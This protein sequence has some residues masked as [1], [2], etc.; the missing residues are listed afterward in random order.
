MDTLQTQRARKLTELYN[1]LREPY[2]ILDDRLRLLSDISEA[3]SDENT[4]RIIELENLFERERQMLKCKVVG[5]ALEILRQRELAV[6]IDVI[7]DEERIKPAKTTHRMCEKCKHVLPTTNFVMHSRQKSFDLCRK[8]ASLKTSKTDLSVYRSILRGIQRDERKRGAFS[9]FA[10]I[11]NE[12]DIKSIFDF[13]W[14]GISLLSQSN[15]TSDLR[16]PRWNVDEEWSPWNCICLTDSEAKIHVN[17][18]FCDLPHVYGEKIIA[19]CR[20]KHSLAKSTFRHLKKIDQ[21]I[22]ESD[23]WHNYG[24]NN[25]FV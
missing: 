7:K 6:F 4:S 21:S 8:C 19:E 9:S 24:K 5:S 13:I 11:L 22:V 18:K 10:F 2:K 23:D 14:H 12:T 15:M 1:L 16:L 25:K 20:S 17:I 3:L